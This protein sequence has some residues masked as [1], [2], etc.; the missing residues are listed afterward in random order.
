MKIS[1]DVGLCSGHGRCYALTPA[2]F[3][4]DDRGF[5]HVKDD[6]TV[7]PSLEQEAHRAVRSC[8]EHAISIEE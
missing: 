3:V 5:G 4:D 6:G 2:I 8:P 7:P 1:I